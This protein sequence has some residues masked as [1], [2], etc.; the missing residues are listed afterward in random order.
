MKKILFVVVG[1]FLLYDISLAAGSKMVRGYMKKD[2]TYV[3]PHR[4]TNKDYS[5]FNNYSTKGNFNP[6]TGK[7]GKKDPFKPSRRKKR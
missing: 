4:R 6:Y 3:E 7:K 2:G 1:L 5:K